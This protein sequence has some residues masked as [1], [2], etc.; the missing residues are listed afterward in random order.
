MNRIF[1]KEKENYI[2][3]TIELKWRHCWATYIYKNDI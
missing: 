3:V 1:K 2:K